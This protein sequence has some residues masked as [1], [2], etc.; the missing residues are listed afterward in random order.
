MKTVMKN[1]SLVITIPMEEKFNDKGNLM[2][3]SSH[4]WQIAGEYDGAPLRVN[5]NAMVKGK[6]L[7][8]A[9][10]PEKPVKTARVKKGKGK[11]GVSLRDVVEALN[12]AGIAL[13]D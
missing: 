2:V 10:E 9:Q 13:D 8:A 7:T 6:D 5:L 12:A 1:G 11:K 3:A 4:G